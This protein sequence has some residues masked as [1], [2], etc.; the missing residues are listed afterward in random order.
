MVQEH[1]LGCAVA[2]VAFRCG[3]PYKKAITLFKERSHAWTRGYYCEEVVYALKKAG[4][5]YSFAAFE[6]L[7]FPDHREFL[8]SEGTIAFVEPSAIYPVGHYLI[9]HGGR[10]MNPWLNHP[11]LVPV[12]AGFQIK[13][14]GRASYIVFENSVNLSS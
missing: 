8:K 2:C 12:E 1:A 11:Q 4:F 10:W 3:V 14:P 5:D 9:R 13:M 7:S 6:P